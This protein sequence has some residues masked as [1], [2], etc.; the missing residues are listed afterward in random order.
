M[1]QHTVF[2][3]AE[4]FPQMILPCSFSLFQCGAAQKFNLRKSTSGR[5]SETEST[6]FSVTAVS[7]T[8]KTLKNYIY[9]CHEG[10]D[11]ASICLLCVFVYV[12]SKDGL[13]TSNVLPKSPFYSFTL[14][15]SDWLRL[16]PTAPRI[17]T[18]WSKLEHHCV[19]LELQSGEAI[20]RNINTLPYD[21]KLQYLSPLSFL[22]SVVCCDVSWRSTTSQLLVFSFWMTVCV[23]APLNTTE[24]FDWNTV[25][26]LFL[27][28]LNQHYIKVC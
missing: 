11:A 23:C 13:S 26:R 10:W 6:L 17:Q 9:Q 1:K 24:I 3:Q 4:S 14:L 27:L 2:Q 28:C 7:K 16:N 8:R 20:Q 5:G 25:C 19:C 18:H 15:L 12:V 22:L 21:E